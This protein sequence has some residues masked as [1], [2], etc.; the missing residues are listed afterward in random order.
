[1]LFANNANTTV[2]HNGSLIVLNG[3]TNFVSSF[4]ATLTL[5]KQNVINSAWYEKSRSK[6]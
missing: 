4:G 5:Y 1:M 2:V 3:S 6:P